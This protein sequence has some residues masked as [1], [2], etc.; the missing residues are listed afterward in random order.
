MKIPSSNIFR[1]ILIR[2]Q[3]ATLLNVLI[4]FMLYLLSYFQ[5]YPASHH[6]RGFEFHLRHVKKLPVTLDEVVV[7]TVYY[8]FLNHLQLTAHDF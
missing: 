3:S 5:K 8:G 4:E 6:F 2:I 1:K 7:L